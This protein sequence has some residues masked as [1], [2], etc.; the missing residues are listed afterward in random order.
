MVKAEDLVYKAFKTLPKNPQLSQP[1]VYASETASISS[2]HESGVTTG[3]KK[4]RNSILSYDQFCL[5]TGSSSPTN[6]VCYIINAVRKRKEETAS[7]AQARKEAIENFL[8]E[9]RI[10]G[11]KEFLLDGLSN[12]LLLNL[13]PHAQ[14]DQYALIAIV[15]PLTLLSL[16]ATVL[17]TSNIAWQR[18]CTDAGH[19]TPRPVFSTTICDTHNTFNFIILSPL[20]ALP[21]RQPITVLAN[22]QLLTDSN[23]NI[24]PEYVPNWVPLRPGHN[25][26]ASFLMD[27][28]EPFS[29]QPTT[30]RRSD[31]LPSYI[32]LAINAKTKLDHADQQGWHLSDPVLMTQVALRRVHE[33]FFFNPTIPHQG[34]HSESSISLQNPL[35]LSPTTPTGAWVPQSSSDSAV[36]FELPSGNGEHEME[37]EGEDEDEDDHEQLYGSEFNTALVKVNDPAVSQGDRDQLLALLL[38]KRYQNLPN[39]E[40]F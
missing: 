33:E 20:G 7:A 16:L 24:P 1:P 6:Q 3:W 10:K 15:S 26:H 8:T 2:T 22:P 37:W 14:W 11:N 39:L 35:P 40:T 17:E 13:D 36:G 30:S 25:N 34:R 32:A 9:R 23:R 4:I 5:L 38:T 19:L 31:D 27:N 21:N 12:L 18:A 29:R 28:D